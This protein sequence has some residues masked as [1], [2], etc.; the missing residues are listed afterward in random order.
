MNMQ[1]E[2]VRVNQLRGISEMQRVLVQ[3]V[4]ASPPQVHEG[5]VIHLYSNGS[6]SISFDFVN[7]VRDRH[8]LDDHGH[9]DI[10]NVRPEL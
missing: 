10:H 6:A 3:D 9:V 1:A 2:A 5:R 4:Q 7:T 8:L